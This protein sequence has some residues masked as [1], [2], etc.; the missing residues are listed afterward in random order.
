MCNC[1]SFAV[2][3][4]HL[5]IKFCATYLKKKE[6]NKNLVCSKLQRNRIQPGT[7]CLSDVVSLRWFC[8]RADIWRSATNTAAMTSVCWLYT[9]SVGQHIWLTF[10]GSYTNTRRLLR[11]SCF[12]WWISICRKWGREEHSRVCMLKSLLP[13]FKQA[14]NLYW[15]ASLILTVIKKEGKN[16]PWFI[17][18]FIWVNSMPACF[19][20]FSGWTICFFCKIVFFW[21]PKK[22][23]K[24]SSDQ[25]TIISK[26]N[27]QIPNFFF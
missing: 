5:L 3:V 9:C 1:I 11:A 21:A 25:H 10:G 8:D 27:L 17:Y 19:L 4:L 20:F 24:E 16:C 18:F 22:A 2:T 14:T 13:T 7:K 6:L 26:L 23:N 12:T 15:W